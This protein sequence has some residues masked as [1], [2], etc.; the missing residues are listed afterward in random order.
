L[1]A[2]RAAIDIA[3]NTRCRL[4]IVHVSSGRGVEL[5]AAARSQGVDVTCETCPHYLLLT[6]QDMVAIGSTAKCAPPLRPQAEQKE[7]RDRISEITT[8][9]SDHSP[10]PPPMKRSENFFEVWGGISSCQHLLPLVQTS[11]LDEDRIGELTSANVAERFRLPQKGGIAVGKDA[12]LTLLD[13]KDCFTVTAGG[14]NYRHQQTPY[15]GRKIPRIIR[16]ILRGQ[17]IAADGKVNAR[18][19]GKLVRPNRS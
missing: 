19:T 11:G 2:I 10:A 17:T 1:D 3:A 5:V 6:A 14:L 7:L 15:L 18:P 16:T 9:G 12:D 8:I 13:P 4:H